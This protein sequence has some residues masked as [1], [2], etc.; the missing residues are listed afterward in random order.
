MRKDWV[1]ERAASYPRIP[2]MRLSKA[3]RMWASAA[4][5]SGVGYPCL[6][7]AI[8]VAVQGCNRRGGF[9]ITIFDERS[10]G[11][12]LKPRLERVVVAGE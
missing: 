11:D 5:S 6:R 3:A 4:L 1:A 9:R 10:R 7:F 8:P 2:A 12:N